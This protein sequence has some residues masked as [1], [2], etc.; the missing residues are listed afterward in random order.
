MVYYSNWMFKSL[1]AKIAVDLGA[2]YLRVLVVREGEQAGWEINVNAVQQHLIEEIACVARARGSGKVLAVGYE[3]LE[4]RGRLDQ[5]VEVVFPFEVS[6]LV[7]VEAARRLLQAV[8]RRAFNQHLIIQPQVMVVTNSQI[9]EITRQSISD[10]FHELGFAKVHLVAAPLAAAIGAGVP[11]ADASGA[12]ILHLGASSVEA[13][14]IGLA[15][16]LA[17]KHSRRAGNHIDQAIRDLLARDEQL[18]IGHET[19]TL[20]KEQ[21]LQLDSQAPAIQKL[22]V[23]G[24]TVQ[25][26]LPQALHVKS[27]LL[28]PVAAQ[29][30]S[31]YVSLLREL[32]Q[33]V[34][35]DLTTDLLHKGL[36]LTG[37]LAQ[38]HGLEA[39]LSREL[40]L[41]VA[42]VEESDKLAIMGAVLLLRNI[43][44]TGGG[45]SYGAKR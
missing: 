11:V 41:P 43:A 1:S 38:L 9:S 7:E 30:R 42:L 18:L 10:L 23:V 13:S 28:E 5:E 35:P 15:S 21:L 37:G 36:L 34:P 31:E 12:C 40:Q 39:F 24:Q 16:V 25:Q 32:L 4:M 22:E 17:V 2:R 19:A 27:S 33:A 20:L 26:H 45:L 3:A 14:M 29:M 44:R 8:L 6:R